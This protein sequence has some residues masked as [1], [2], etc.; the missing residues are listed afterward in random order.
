M[1]TK[2]RPSWYIFSFILLTSFVLIGIARY[3]SGDNVHSLNKRSF[4][5]DEE[6]SDAR[7]GDILLTEDEDEQNASQLLSFSTVDESKGESSSTDDSST[8]EST[9]TTEDENKQEQIDSNDQVSPL[10]SLDETSD[11][12]STV[13]GAEDSTT[14]TTNESETTDD[15]TSTTATD[16]TPDDQTTISGTDETTSDTVGSTDE[17]SETAD[18]SEISSTSEPASSEEEISASSESEPTDETSETPDTSEISLTSEPTSSEEETSASSESEST[19]DTAEPSEPT[20]DESTS[21]NHSTEESTSEN[22]ADSESP[23]T[24]DE[25]T[26]TSE[27]NPEIAENT[28]ENETENTESTTSEILETESEETE[29]TNQQTESTNEEPVEAESVPTTSTDEASTSTA[30]ETE[31]SSTQTEESSSSE[32][33][34]ASETETT[35]EPSTPEEVSASSNESTVEETSTTESSADPGNS[36]SEIESGVEDTKLEETDESAPQVDAGDEQISKVDDEAEGGGDA[37]DG[38]AATDESA[39]ISTTS[40]ADSTT[41]VEN[42]ELSSPEPAGE[43]P[44]A[45]SASET[46][47]TV[48]LEPEASSASET[49]TTVA[50]ETEAPSGSE[51]EAASTS[52][53][54]AS[55]ASETESS[56]E[57]TE[58][59]TN[60]ES[61]SEVASE[62]SSSEVTSETT[63]AETEATSGTE[64]TSSE[65]VE[66]SSS[67]E[68]IETS[69]SEESAV[70]T[71][72]SVDSSTES[73]AETKESETTEQTVTTDVKLESTSETVTETDSATTGTDEVKSETTA[74]ETDETVTS[75][76]PET[77]SDVSSEESTTTPTEN[78]SS[79]SSDPL[80]DAES[81]SVESSSI[82]EASSV[83]VT[84]EVASTSFTEEAK[85]LETTTE[86]TC[87]SEYGC[88]G[89]EKTPAKGINQEGCTCD[90]SKHGCCPDRLTEATGPDN[91]GCPCQTTTYG[92]CPNSTEPASGPKYSGCDC[93]KTPYGCCQDGQS[94]S[95]GPDYEGCESGVPLDTRLAGDACALPKER[96]PGRNYS[97]Q[98]YFDMAYGGCI[99]FWYG[100]REGNANRFE[101][102]EQCERTCVNPE[103]S[104]VCSLPKVT[105]PCD[106]KYPSYFYNKSSGQCE[107]FLFGGCLGNGNR[108]DTIEQCRETCDY[109]P[110]STED[111]CDQPVSTGSNCK[112]NHVRFYFN[113]QDGRCKQFIWGGCAAN[114]NNFITMSDC[115][116]TCKSATPGAI[117]KMNKSP[118]PC[119]GNYPRWYFDSI[120]GSCKEFIYTGCQGNRNQ[121]VDKL[122]CEKTCNQT[123]VQEK[124][125]I[126][127]LEKDPGPCNGKQIHWYYNSKANRCMKF[128]Y[129]GCEGNNNN[130]QAQAD[131]ERTCVISAQEQDICLLPRNVGNCSIDRSSSSNLQERW[132]YDITDKRC[133]RMYYT[134]CNG[135]GNNFKSIEE[136][137]AHCGEPL[138]PVQVEET[139]TRENFKS[140]SCSLPRDPG[141]CRMFETKYWYDKIDGVCKQFYYGGCDGNLNRFNSKKQCERNCWNSQDICMLKKI[142]GPCSGNFIQWYYNST[143]GTCDEFSF[144]G[145]SGNANRFS[146]KE[147]CES[148]CKKKYLTTNEIESSNIITTTNEGHRNIKDDACQGPSDPGNCQEYLTKYHY[149]SRENMCHAF[150]YTGCGG[151]SN[152]FDNRRQC[153]ARCVTSIHTDDG[154]NDTDD[155]ETICRMPVESGPCYETHSRYYYDPISYTCIPFVYGGCGG[156]KNRFKKFETCIN[157]CSNV[158]DHNRYVPDV[159][160]SLPE[161]NIEDRASRPLPSSPSTSYTPVSS[162]TIE[163]IPS[164][165]E[166]DVTS[167]REQITTLPST[168]TTRGKLNRFYLTL[169]T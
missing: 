105:G 63:V 7:R 150:V 155:K 21:E 102:H 94:V 60:D 111:P 44:E 81:T 92:C 52:E 109:K 61:T 69:T 10:E 84:T 30:T 153:E 46:G 19:D 101:T 56:S 22:T 90:T 112:G 82:D 79:T 154:P 23:S 13:T 26:S 149:D 169:D 32:S 31:T 91:E 62:E 37:V 12:A 77:S 113:K 78:E 75:T 54:E 152:R 43:E 83:N 130:F 66:I 125:E 2:T 68:T 4:E 34:S 50:P 123:Q 93:S 151:N 27:V 36:N 8:I 138:A 124:G 135:N 118:G 45:S 87:G 59:T 145:C 103:G 164:Y 29:P 51:T 28:V 157:Y 140:E 35:S 47:T 115:V 71:D 143:T 17:T 137:R 39:S 159:S 20:T 129:G 110:N 24:S 126:C 117:C 142:R 100:G 99:R 139:I 16:E 167:H 147:S 116:Q 53:T 33:T 166:P 67:S 42:S 128:I 114:A 106:G 162:V 58:A 72:E 146:Q 38:A 104:E 3:S 144:S 57:N 163:S 131:C 64:S 160:Q 156:N 9:A 122:T 127:S 76:E 89:D 95:F 41:E 136:C 85:S 80:T 133:H 25:N 121:F 74:G 73:V 158:N 107:S 15:Q 65:V 40:E 132:W 96:G 161:I 6:S 18:T 70:P 86:N 108:F 134:G 119:L 48:A 55:S 141:P 11:T 49:E 165:S 98:W 120:D 97:V 88:C 5:M 148:H 1:D 168:T 14:T